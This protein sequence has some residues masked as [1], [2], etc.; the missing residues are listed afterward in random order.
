MP[1]FSG[2]SVGRR[3]RRSEVGVLGAKIKLAAFGAGSEG[4]SDR[5]SA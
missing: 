3:E 2:L 5:V 1:A 4:Y